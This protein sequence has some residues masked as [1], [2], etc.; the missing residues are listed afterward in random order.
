MDSKGNSPNTG[1][2]VGGERRNRNQLSDASWL[3]A[4]MATQGMGWSLL[5]MHS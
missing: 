4:G 5:G 1:G 3:A 2:K